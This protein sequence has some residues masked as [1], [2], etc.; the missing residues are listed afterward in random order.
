[1]TA[2]DVRLPRRGA[3]GEQTPRVLAGHTRSQITRATTA[4][5]DIRQT[6][7]QTT[8]TP[9]HDT[10]TDSETET[11]HS[12]E[13]PYHVGDPVV[14]LAQG[15]PM[16]VLESPETTVD[17]W[18]AENGYQLMDNY[19]N[20]KLDTTPSMPVV[21]CVYLSDIRSEPS[22]DYTFPASRVALIDAHHA[23]DGRRI[24]ERVQLQVLEELFD[25]A[26]RSGSDRTLSVLEGLTEDALGKDVTSEA[27]ELASV[28]YMID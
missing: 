18:S 26:Y 27:R 4:L 28:D 16:L 15:R 8:M 11:E 17:E 22:K 25:A 6:T 13:Q 5:F 1:M 7:S 21:R 24:H 23:D 9:S 20:S 2:R 3:G 14:D 19:A 12:M 10:D